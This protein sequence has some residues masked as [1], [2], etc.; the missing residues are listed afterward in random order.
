MPGLAPSGSSLH[1]RIVSLL[2]RGSPRQAIRR[3]AAIH[4]NKRP[5]TGHDRVSVRPNSAWV[6]K[7]EVAVKAVIEVPDLAKALADSIP[8][9][10]E[11][12]LAVNRAT[13]SDL[14]FE[15]GDDIEEGDLFAV[16]SNR[17]GTCEIKAPA[18]GM[19]VSLRHEED[20]AVTSEEVLATIDT[21]RGCAPSGGLP[22]VR[23]SA[24]RPPLDQDADHTSVGQRACDHK[25]VE[26]PAD[27]RTKAD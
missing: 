3:V 14:Y 9:K 17:Y 12:H 22:A 5:L 15:E 18:S 8:G 24:S 25:G 20:D 1:H 4:P 23:L 21:D 19:L 7:I 27:H 16:I 10:A 2:R 11:D 6:T 13:L 26:R